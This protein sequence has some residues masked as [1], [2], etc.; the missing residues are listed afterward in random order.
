MVACCPNTKR[1]ATTIVSTV[2]VLGQLDREGCSR[3]A[4]VLERL[5][6]ECVLIVGQSGSFVTEVFDSVDW[7]VKH[8][9][10]ARVNCCP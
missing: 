4:D 8:G 1:Q 5:P 2:Q 10:V 9:G 3:V 6:Q 7:V